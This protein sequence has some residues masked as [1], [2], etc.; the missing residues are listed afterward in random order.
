[1]VSQKLLCDWRC[2]LMVE[3]FPNMYQALN[4][5]PCTA[6]KK[7]INMHLKD[8]YSSSSISACTMSSTTQMS[9][10]WFLINMFASLIAYAAIYIQFCRSVCMLA[11]HSYIISRKCELCCI[12][13]L[14]RL[15]G[16]PEGNYVANITC[17]K[18]L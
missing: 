7:A 9:N 6:K 10:N 4:S 2:S 14:H 16:N 18:G 8:L 5:I 15:K 3:G 17:K 1:M 13:S 11:I 12:F